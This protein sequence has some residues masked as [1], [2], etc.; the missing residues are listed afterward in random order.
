MLISLLTANSTFCKMSNTKR[1][2]VRALND[3]PAS[4]VCELFCAHL[5]SLF[6]LAQAMTGSTEGAEVVLLRAINLAVS[7]TP[8]NRQYAYRVV[9]RCVVKACIESLADELAKW[10]AIE[11]NVAIT[12]DTDN[13]TQGLR[14]RNEVSLYAL[15]EA[16]ARINPLR[17]VAVI[18]KVLER[19]HPTDVALLLGQPS[20]LIAQVSIKG[21]EELCYAVVTG[22]GQSSLQK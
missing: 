7:S 4:T 20:S 17:R 9:R 16:L 3:D 10:A 19:Y 21:L 8:A 2:A 5:P 22:A 13:S 18:L 14:P 11:R 12:T 15:T 1:A 6:F